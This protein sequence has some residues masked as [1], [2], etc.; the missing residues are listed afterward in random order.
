MSGVV[1]P[2]EI[3]KNP[4]I[5]P[6]NI[7]EKILLEDFTRKEYSTFI[8]KAELQDFGQ[9]VIDRIYYWTGGNPRMTWDIC[10]ALQNKEEKSESASK[11]AAPAPAPAPASGA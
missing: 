6:F 7:G 3:I 8:E 11:P 4:K 1:E 9:K 2:T 5:S 10:Y